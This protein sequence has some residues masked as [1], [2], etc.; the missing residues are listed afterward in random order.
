M[1]DCP[2]IPVCSFFLEYGDTSGLKAAV[3]GFVRIYCKGDLQDKCVRKAVS[4]ALGGPHMVPPN[5]LPNGYP[6][7]G[8]NDSAWSPHVKEIVRAHKGS[9]QP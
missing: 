9:T 8:T 4:K 1:A 6:V 3:S 7:T 5:V 2:N